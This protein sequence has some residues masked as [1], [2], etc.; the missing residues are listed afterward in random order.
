M[1]EATIKENYLHVQ[2]N[3][4]KKSNYNLALRILTRTEKGSEDCKIEL[5]PQKELLPS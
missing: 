3:S 2:M 4:E 1:K 5:V